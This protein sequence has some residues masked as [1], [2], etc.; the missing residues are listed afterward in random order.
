MAAARNDSQ[1]RVVG[2]GSKS[3]VAKEVMLT[4]EEAEAPRPRSCG[5]HRFR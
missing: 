1:F 5:L 2:T 4:G 3:R